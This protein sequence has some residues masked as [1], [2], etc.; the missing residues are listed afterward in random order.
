MPAE[1]LRFQN[2]FAFLTRLGG[3]GDQVESDDGHDGRAPFI[4][5]NV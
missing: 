5:S 4:N 1:I 2:Q 3:H